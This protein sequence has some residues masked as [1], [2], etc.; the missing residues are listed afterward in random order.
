[1]ENLL[2]GTD[3]PGNRIETQKAIV[4]AAQTLLTAEWAA[5]VTFNPITQKF[6][7]NPV[8]ISRLRARDVSPL[9]SW[10]EG[11]AISALP[12]DDSYVDVSSEPPNIE[13]NAF[14]LKDT[15]VIRVLVLRT[16]REQ[17]PIG[18]LFVGFRAQP[19][20]SKKIEEA[21]AAL[22]LQV[23]PILE[24]IW[25]LNRYRAVV[26]IGQKL[27]RE[28]KGYRDLFEKLLND[29]AGIIDT[30]YFFML[31]VHQPQ[32]NTHDRYF[33]FK[34]GRP[35]VQIDLELEGACK[36]V[37]KSGRPIHSFHRSQDKSWDVDH[38][39]LFGKANHDAEPDP[40]SVIFEPLNF[41]GEILGLLTVQRLEPC[42][43]DQE[44][45]QILKLLG[46]QVAL[47]LSNF[48]L[49]NYLETLNDVG[50]KLTE[51]LTSED[52]LTDVANKVMEAT[53]ADIVTLYPYLSSEE[54][55]DRPV[56]SGTL[57][58]PDLL[59]PTVIT[60]N[61]AWLTLKT[62][63]PVWAKDS[64]QLYETL[65]GDPKIRAGNFEE[66]ER[67]ASTVALVLRIDN[68]ANGVMFVNFRIAQRFRPFQQKFILGL[69][70]YAAIAIK[71]YRKYTALDQRRYDDL[72]VLQKIDRQMRLTPGLTEI[73]R[74][75]LEGAVNRIRAADESAIILYDHR[76]ERLKT[77]ESIGSDNV[78][79]R[80][81]VLPVNA[82][83]G[84]ATWVYRNKLPVRVDNV[85]TDPKWREIYYPVIEDT[86]SEMD[87][88]LSDEDEVIGVI[89]FE[90]KKEKAFTRE[91]QEFIETLAGQ[92]VLAIKN[93]QLNRRA[94]LAHKEL[95]TLHEVAQRITILQT[96]PEEVMK[97]I[98]K[99][100]RMLLG[101]E[102]GALQLYEGTEPGK[103]Y[104]SEINTPAER[105]DVITINP[106]NNSEKVKLG[107]VQHVA[108]TRESYITAGD[109]QEDHYYQGIEEY[110]SE[111]TVPLISR[112]DNLIGVLD[113][114][115]P[116][117][118]A[119]DRDDLKVLEAFARQAVIAIQYAQI[120]S[121]SFAE[122]EH[123][124]LLSEAGR[125]L[126]ALTDKDEIDQAYR[127]ILS[128]V[129]EFNDGEI[130]VRRY[131]ETTQE[132][133]L[134][135]V[136]N[137][138]PT[139]PPLSIPKNKGINGQVARERRTIVV[140]D[141]KN[142]PEGVDEP[143]GDDPSI[144][145]L[146][147]TPILLQEARYYGNLVLSH[148]K[149]YSL[150]QSD[151]S[152]LEGLAQQL[153]I[154]IHR[155]DT[156]QARMEAEQQAKDLEIVVE[157]GESGMQIA[158]RL[159]DELALVGK[160]VLDIRQALAGFGIESS[161]IDE[162]LDRIMKDVGNVLSMSR[163]LKQK[164]AEIGE[165][166]NTK[167]R[168]CVA[169]KALLYESSWTPL[170]ENIPIIWDLAHDLA[171]VNVVPGQIVDIMRNLVANAREVMPDGGRI[172]IRAYN[173]PPNV[174]IEV[175]D[176]GPGIPVKHQHKIFNIF[177][178]TKKS[179]GF[180]LWSARRYA[181]A[182]G[183]DLTMRSE[184]GSG[185]TFIL[186][187]PMVDV[188]LEPTTTISNGNTHE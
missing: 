151:I 24:N 34:E 155:L 55:F 173:V 8:I 99:H 112:E 161:D 61:I 96:D 157:F 54:R 64:R 33:S 42:G 139:P 165:A 156:V 36:A 75:I 187:L 103:V 184:H 32:S 142:L 56:Y 169:V 49:F 107:I 41:R 171:Y 135:D 15:G 118:Y 69:A 48:R 127:I 182:N 136:M 117:H 181:R 109:A 6:H 188:P 50:Q 124:R 60:D 128:K 16:K 163:G 65:G 11:I 13:I 94:E 62:G 185:A 38:I 141:I 2:L 130:L 100:A 149:A 76:T 119:F 3:E 31:A 70:N 134:K 85:K 21:L 166:G 97:F 111:I 144:R 59:L 20:F 57:R 114:E 88:P 126:G 175:Q 27:N 143:F 168:T 121:N 89:S 82:D 104:L 53:G 183:G 176:T 132:L 81:L 164:V 159:G 120:Y 86:L 22:L 186:Q 92:A 63:T 98:L 122:S 72:L 30:S 25:L 147:I 162:G 93:A 148:E 35:V 18:V 138:R 129:A 7:G 146:V 87:V 39:E 158:H 74:P 174:L 131:N 52:L 67:V 23:S 105:P 108:E 178:S 90:S 113:L 154:T 84:L 68:E 179:S 152:L 17:K 71:N 10:F 5:M 153:A 110:H 26:K 51:N 58:R 77:A 115:S 37:I 101:A 137:V 172:D 116:R 91:D 140:P 43:Y 66:R 133:E 44:D 102:M 123:F 4:N 46:N 167:D 180:G 125:D 83:K 177:F 12:H 106:I 40:E 80:H 95:E 150:S 160:Y 29:V 14:S 19:Q 1:M 9:Q 79:Y 170:P 28:L 45:I 73:L 78:K 145:T 47:A